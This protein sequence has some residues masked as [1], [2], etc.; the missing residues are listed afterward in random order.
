[1]LGKRA[2]R[3]VLL[4]SFLPLLLL[5]TGCPDLIGGSNDSGGSNGGDD[6]GGSDN[7]GTTSV[8]APEFSL[9]RGRYVGA[10]ELTI[11]SST[12]GANIYYRQDF[13][14]PTDGDTVYD[15]PL[16]IEGSTILTAVAEVNGEYSDPVSRRIAIFDSESALE[17]GN[18]I[19][20]GDFEGGAGG[21]YFYLRS[22]NPDRSKIPEATD[23]DGDG[24]Q[25]LVLNITDDGESVWHAQAGFDVGFPIEEGE[26]YNVEFTA[27]L[28]DT[29]PEDARA[30]STEIGN[31]GVSGAEFES[32][33]YRRDVL[34]KERTTYSFPFG[35]YVEDG[36]T[37]PAALLQ[38]YFGEHGEDEE[39]LTV[40]LDDVSITKESD[41]APFSDLYSGAA[42]SAIE[43]A[44]QQ[45]EDSRND[46]RRY[47]SITAAS[48][49]EYHLAAVRRVVWFENDDGDDPE[50]VDPS[51]FELP[52]LTIFPNIRELTIN[53]LEVTDEDIQNIGGAG[54]LTELR[55]ENSRRDGESSNPFTEV[56]PLSSLF[57]LD[58]LSLIEG[59]FSVSELVSPLRPDSFPYLENLEIS[60]E[61]LAGLSDSEN[62]ALIDIYSGFVNAGNQFRDIELISNDLS[63]AL[64]DELIDEVLVP[65]EPW[66][67][68]LV[69]E[70]TQMSDGQ[71]ET[72]AQLSSLNDLDVSGAERVTDFTPLGSHS[73]WTELDVGSTAVDNE[74]M[75]LI[76]SSTNLRTLELDGTEITSLQSIQRLLDSG[77]FDGEGY[78]EL[79]GN[80]QL[81]LASGTANGD[82]LAALEAAGVEVEYDDS[83]LEGAAGGVD[84]VITDVPQSVVDADTVFYVT[85]SFGDADAPT[86]LVGENAADNG[87]AGSVEIDYV[88]FDNADGDSTDD[89]PIGEEVRLRIF[90]GF[91]TDNFDGYGGDYRFPTRGE[92]RLPERTVTINGNEE[93]EVS[94]DDF[95]ER[96]D[97]PARFQLLKHD[98]ADEA[99]EGK[100]LSLKITD[101]ADNVVGK[102]LR[103]VDDRIDDT[104]D[105][106]LRDDFSVRDVSAD[107][108]YEILAFE[109]LTGTYSVSV[110]LDMDDSFDESAESTILTDGDYHREFSWNLASDVDP[111]NSRAGIFFEFTED[112][113]YSAAN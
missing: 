66:L 47:E 92:Y 113:V 78:V 36:F 5:L 13:E 62:A 101:A 69:L 40:Y 100:W 31:L 3:Y 96:T 79:D 56:D 93:L 30:F 33:Q 48:I 37:Y 112:D 53:E 85:G 45:A 75:E 77:A 71:F 104:E 25:E 106:P 52:P 38:L 11:S 89:I 81:S 91:L 82:T 90:T 103:P 67:E 32:F 88:Y 80:P 6:S 58:E 98:E 44:V 17:S 29:Y 26:L 73:R 27:W 28:D 109:S 50:G 72:I 108:Y 54:T 83:Q 76:E 23:A 84:I 19:P 1:M 10:Q 64:V 9:D 42:N 43:R 59:E 8:S 12:E 15:G 16:T 7:G 102:A 61:H 107:W 110:T 60:F 24:N 20:G 57:L 34:T 2:K 94:Y 18:Q 4:L 55:I 87:T 14:I 35:V 105:T 70:N 111:A 86:L 46:E 49:T 99:W 68:E 63:E 65:S 22:E 95:T 74:A 21:W 51:A 97:Y 41:I 39:S